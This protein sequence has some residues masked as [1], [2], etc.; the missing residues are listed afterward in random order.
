MQLWL[1]VA[2]PLIAASL[3]AG[4]L[5]AKRS[6]RPI[7]DIN[8]QLA[9]MKPQSLHGGIRIPE[10]DPV[11]EGLANHL[12][13]LLG[14]A[15]DAYRDMA[16]FSSKVAHELRTPLMLLRMRIEQA[17]TGTCPEFQEELQNE[18][19]RLGRYVER[20][21]LAA[22]AERQAL[23][24]DCRYLALSRMLGEIA[25]DYALLA[26]ERELEMQ[27][28]I[29]PE[30]EVHNDPDLLRQLLHSLLENAVRYADRR[31]EV[32]LERV[33]SRV[34]LKISNDYREIGRATPGLGLGLRLARGICDAC[35]M[36]LQ[37]CDV[38]TSYEVVVEFPV[39]QAVAD[40]ESA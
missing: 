10:S 29:V 16:E 2:A 23:I 36:D 27:V 33:D 4:F 38:G 7:D 13:T 35:G 39:L 3:G 26:A 19:S 17:P 20:A 24:P 12:N 14:R 5:L 21:L 18:L 11:I 34:R 8:L 1:W 32:V 25:D 40:A 9:E 28:R 22:K 30:L 15:G 31:I 37:I 6:L